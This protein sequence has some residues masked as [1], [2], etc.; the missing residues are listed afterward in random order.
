[1]CLWGTSSAPPQAAPGLLCAV[2]RATE[3]QGVAGPT[4]APPSPWRLGKLSRASALRVMGA[5]G[6][7]A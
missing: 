4:G 3:N 7:S 1:M 5:R 2:L 6:W